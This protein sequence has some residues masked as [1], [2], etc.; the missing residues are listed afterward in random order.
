VVVLP[1]ED[2]LR[3]AGLLLIL[4]AIVVVWIRT[5]MAGRKGYVVAYCAQDQ[6]YAEPAFREF[7][8]QG[9]LKVR[10]VYD[11]EAVKTVGLANRLLAERS[12]PQCDVFWGNEEMRAR[13][14]ASR[15]VFAGTNGLAFFGA[16]SRRFVCN[17]NLLPADS[18]PRSLLELTNEFWHGKIAL[19]FPQFGTTA[20]HFHALRQLWG[21]A[22]WDQWCRGL[23]ATKPVIVDGNS[24]VVSTVGRGDAWIG[25]TDS[26]DIAAGQRE[27][28]PIVALPM[29]AETLLIPN[30]VAIAAAAP[31]PEG[32]RKLFEYLQ[33]PAVAQRLVEVKALE[34]TNLASERGLK[35]NWDLMLSNLDSTT[36]KLNEIFL[37]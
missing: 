30:A 6:V 17:T 11:S 36:A 9:G 29:S 15:G 20:T 34:T 16:R 2:G 32:A 28:L 25:L 24:V 23:A 31:N 18:A 27:G 10:A 7:E 3:K 33:T 5:S 35:V 1:S 22:A 12:N 13:Q 21:E 4:A 26:D 37:R 8:R 14:L 19:A